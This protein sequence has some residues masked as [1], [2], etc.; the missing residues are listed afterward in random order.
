MIPC[1][2]SLTA[3]FVALL[4]SLF[5]R[6]AEANQPAPP[7]KNALLTVEELP[8]GFQV[9]IE[10]PPLRGVPRYGVT[11]VRLI[12]SGSSRTFD[13]LEI[14]LI[15]DPSLPAADAADSFIRVLEAF[16]PVADLVRVADPSVG[17]NAIRYSFTADL[18][19]MSANGNLIV[20]RRGGVLGIAGLLTNGDADVLPYAALQDAK[21][22]A[23]LGTPSGIAS[24]AMTAAP[25]VGLISC[26]SFTHQEAAQLVLMLVPGDPY[27][28]DLNDNGIAC[29]D[30]SERVSLSRGAARSVPAHR[31]PGG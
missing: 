11:F 2:M 12:G 26:A 5:S 3:A 9:F 25:L 7:L 30:E 27:G 15:D 6:P 10:Q 19:G 18:R 22:V 13:S 16:G 21:L 17:M 23:F 20:W 29:D 8:P 1:R 4:V 31:Y 14:D 28:L 24:P